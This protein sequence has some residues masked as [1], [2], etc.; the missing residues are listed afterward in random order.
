MADE[1]IVKSARLTPEEAKLL[2]EQQISF[3]DLV[4][5]SLN[6]KTKEIS[7][8]EKKQLANKLILNG[9]Y[10]IIG[11]C[12]LSVLNFQSNI[13]SIALVGGIG[14]F[15]TVVGS[16]QLFIAIREVKGYKKNARK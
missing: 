6:K 5:E 7:K 16:I 10:T 3:T 14:G 13:F 15:F 11:L 9:A 1:E 2:D 12:F 8:N 4:R